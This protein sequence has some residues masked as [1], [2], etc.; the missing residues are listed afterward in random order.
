MKRIIESIFVC[1]AVLA[2][3]AFAEDAY[4]PTDIAWL[5]KKDNNSKGMNPTSLPGT[6]CWKVE[7]ASTALGTGVVSGQDYGYRDKD[8]TTD[9]YNFRIA[10]SVSTFEGNSLSVGDLS[11]N[12]GQVI[13]RTGDG[14]TVDE[15]SFANEGLFLNKGSLHCNSSG[16]QIL[17]G[18]ITVNAS[19]DAPF[20]INFIKDGSWLKI[21][22]QVFSGEGKGLYINSLPSAK[23]PGDSSQKNFVCSFVDGSLSTFHG[24]L[25]CG[26]VAWD[27]R[28]T[29]NNYFKTTSYRAPPYYATVS[30]GSSEM[31]GKLILYPGGNLAAE[32][33]ST[34][35][36]VAE[37]KSVYDWGTNT[38]VVA[39]ADDA[40]SCSLVKV[41]KSL[42]LASP[43][44]IRL[45]GLEQFSA[46][47]ATNAASRLAVFKAPEGVTLNEADFV[48]ERT[49]QNPYVPYLPD[50]RIEIAND[51]DGLSTVWI[52]ARPV[53]WSLA[54]DSGQWDSLF[55]E[56]RKKNWSDGMAPSAEKDYLVLHTIR[57]PKDSS[58]KHEYFGG[59]S[60][61]LGKNDLEFNHNGYGEVT[62]SNLQVVAN[63]KFLTLGPGITV[64]DKQL[65]GGGVATFV[66]NGKISTGGADESSSPN[67]TFSSY[68][69]KA[70]KVNSEILGIGVIT[71]TTANQSYNNNPYVGW[72][73]LLGM[74]TNYYGKFV[75]THSSHSERGRVTHLVFN[76]QRNLGAPR[77]EWTYDAVTLKKGGALMPISSVE[78]NDQTRG[79][80]ISDTNTFFRVPNDVVFTCK[81][82]ITYKGIL[83]KDGPGELALGGP[84]PCFNSDGGTSPTAGKN[85]LDVYEGTLRPLSATAFTGVNLTIT[86]GASLVFNI[87]ASNDDG[88]IGQYGILNKNVNTPMT[89]PSTGYVVK[90]EDPAGILE[91]NGSAVVPICTVKS[92]AK[93][94]L[95]G[96]LKV[97]NPALAKSEWKENA[98]G[99]WTYVAYLV[100]RGTVICIR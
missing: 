24:S 14:G 38:L 82:R 34:V 72:I 3:T 46:H 65:V 45:A 98:D 89:I 94:A 15:L 50:Y 73:G 63:A 48:L 32:S 17:N 68:Q 47:A 11:G 80:Y 41:T 29:K 83:I 16:S 79:I 33:S 60:L 2:F 93:T 28:T 8:V 67:L 61:T 9:S 20:A 42:S 81:E 27:D 74:N 77:S 26:P 70:W 39:M 51:T 100:R 69:S 18:K 95:D 66:L 59:Y 25:I 7:S 1:M 58:G 31:P 55:S 56:D 71:A 75:V 53:V 62:V 52:V 36:S 97:G 6:G 44:R 12:G 84:S 92:S 54:S 96:K 99:S 30:S 86:N 78:L 40:K 19:A 43:L 4:T 88:D 13:F 22:G 90:I 76:D 21:T 91:K 23:Y 57:T 5:V 35:F 64:P 10:K 37:L 85:V 87:P 49:E